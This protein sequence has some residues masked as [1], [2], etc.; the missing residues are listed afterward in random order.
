MT[1]PSINKLLEEL[2][3]ETAKSLLA[4][5]KSGEATAA[6]IGNALKMLKYNGIEAIPTPENPL[7]EL[8]NK[9]PDFLDETETYQ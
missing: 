4:K 2:H 1:E 8:A 5:V 6:E 9:L 7:G 3:L